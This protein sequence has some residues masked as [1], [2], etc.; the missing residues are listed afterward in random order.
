MPFRVLTNVM[1]ISHSLLTVFGRK[2]LEPEIWRLLFRPGFLLVV[3]GRYVFRHQPFSRSY[4]QLTVQWRRFMS[5]NEEDRGVVTLPPPTFPSSLKL[6]QGFKGKG[7]GTAFHFRSRM[8]P[9]DRISN[10]DEFLKRT[11]ATRVLK[12]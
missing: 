9:D 11:C 5:A 8:G 2:I 7:D 6:K 1:R 4:Q 3:N 10:P 12:Y